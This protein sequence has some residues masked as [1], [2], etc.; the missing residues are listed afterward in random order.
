MK[1]INEIENSLN[2]QDT[3]SDYKVGDKLFIADSHKKA[4]RIEVP[5]KIV[6]I[7]DGKFE[8]EALEDSLLY[9]WQGSKKAAHNNQGMKK[10]SVLVMSEVD[11]NNDLQNG[12]IS[13]KKG[14]IKEKGRKKLEA[15]I[16]KQ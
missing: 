4:V 1:L 5:V 9:L 6:K 3:A 8:F 15:E 7:E 14:V 13:H 2:E 10:G 11:V 12:M 16:A